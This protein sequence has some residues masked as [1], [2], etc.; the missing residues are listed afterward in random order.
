MVWEIFRLVNDGFV[1]SDAVEEGGVSVYVDSEHK[2]VYDYVNSSGFVGIT[3]PH[4]LH[5]SLSLNDDTENYS[6]RLKGG[7]IDVTYNLNYDDDSRYVDFAD[8]PYDTSFV[9]TVTNLD[10]LESVD[11]T[12][13]SEYVYFRP[14]GIIE[15]IVFPGE[16]YVDM[17]V[18]FLYTKSGCNMVCL[19]TVLFNGL[20]IEWHDPTQLG[21]VFSDVSTADDYSI[22]ASAFYNFSDVRPNIVFTSPLGVVKTFTFP[23]YVYRDDRKHVA[24]KTI[25]GHCLN[26]GGFITG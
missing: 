10:T 4:R 2:G 17:N 16:G 8:V 6:C 24:N 23:A 21:Y 15:R 7:D 9:L 26:N 14:F 13:V 20:A 5:M 1:L 25:G 12:F 22:W 3:E 19:D 11:I 18:Y